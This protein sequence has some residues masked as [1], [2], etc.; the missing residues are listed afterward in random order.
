ML[1]GL[2][3]KLKFN[4]IGIKKNKIKIGGGH[5]FF[6]FFRVDKYKI[7]NYYINFFFSSKGGRWP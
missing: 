6:F 2:N 1:S 4:F 3:Y 7:L 5:N